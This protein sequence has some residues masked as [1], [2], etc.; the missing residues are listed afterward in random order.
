MDTGKAINVG[1]HVVTSHSSLWELFRQ[2]DRNAFAAI[3]E[4]HINDL[5]HY[6]M[7]FCQQTNLVKDCLQDLFQ[8]LWISKEHLAADIRNVRYYLISS[9]RRRL[10]KAAKNN[11]R[12]H[13]PESW[14]SFEFDFS[15]SKEHQLIQLETLEE[16]K[17]LLHAALSQLTKRQREAIYLRFYQ[18]LSY[19]EVADIMSMQVDSVY[20]TIS[21]AISIL[22][23]N[24]PIPLLLLFLK[25]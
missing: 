9:L 24:L 23:K 17:R 20:N 22:K 13:H 12:Y 25:S 16:Q 4:E 18:N 10:L 1:L 2:G 7:H 5:Y 3:Y 8:D 15:I 14:D 19:Q 11:Q 6:G 21:K